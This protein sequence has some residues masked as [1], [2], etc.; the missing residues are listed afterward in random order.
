[1][2]AAVHGPGHAL[3]Q[4]P[5]VPAIDEVKIAKVVA[6]AIAYLSPVLAAVDGAEDLSVAAE[7]AAAQ[8]IE[9]LDRAEP[10]RRARHGAAL[11]RQVWPP[12]RVRPMM[13]P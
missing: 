13:P 8:R 7:H 1:M 4:G 6:V 3:A 5:S 12:S 9:E 2:L 11:N 10:M